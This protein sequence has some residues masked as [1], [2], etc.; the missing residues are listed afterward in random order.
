[1]AGKDRLLVSFRHSSIR[2]TLPRRP[3]P[4]WEID[5]DDFLKIVGDAKVESTH[6]QI[7]GD[8]V[9]RRTTAPGQYEGL[10]IRSIRGTEFPPHMLV[11]TDLLR[12][13]PY[14]EKKTFEA[15]DTSKSLIDVPLL[16]TAPT[17]IIPQTL[18]ND[19]ANEYT[20]VG[21][22]NWTGRWRTGRSCQNGE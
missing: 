7:T 9:D 4:V 2:L 17:G 21:G 13:Y 16:A 6:K 19:V 8:I 15:G 5:G 11:Y 14:E 18:A 22:D 10:H 3:D 1:M 12:I 20:A